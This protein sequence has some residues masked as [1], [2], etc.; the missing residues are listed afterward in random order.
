MADSANLPLQHGFA[1]SLPVAP[2]TPLP[3]LR[4]VKWTANVLVS[5]FLLG[6]GLWAAIAPLESAAVAGGALE[7][8][9]SRKTIQHLEGG[10]ISKILVSDGDEV[11]AGQVLMRLDDTKARTQFHALQ[12]QLW[13]AQAREARLIAERD[14]RGTIAV[15]R[16][17]DALRGVGA[18][19]NDVLAGQQK[20]L[21][22]RRQVFDSQIAVIKQR[23]AQVVQEITGLTAQERAAAKRSSIIRAE[24]DAV[25]PLVQKGLE[26]RPRLLALEREA[27]EIEG[28]RGEAAAQ[29]SRAY[30]VIAE[31]RANIIKLGSDRDNEI[32]QSLH[33]TQNLL[34]QL[35]ERI[36]AAVDQLS[37][38][39]VRAP[40]NGIVTDL[41]VRTPGGVVGAGT[42][43]MDLVPRQDRLIAHAQIRPED[44]DVV[45]SG[46]GADVQLLSYKQ[47]RMPTLKGT[48]VYVSADSLID[49][50]T[51]Q[52]YY[53][54]KIRLDERQLA[55]LS[56]VELVPGMPVQALIKTGESTVALYVLG[57]LLDSFNVAF[58]ED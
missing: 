54:A 56:D 17:A 37:R 55:Q 8:E 6:F 3:R 48:V 39:E 38:T 50:Q 20:I 57:P 41:R 49:K 28:R 18:L 15:P 40:E 9:S 21:D 12:S 58:R 5:V 14:G 45:H 31:S 33:E 24:L 23:M 30:Q 43:L 4:R 47:R 34:V 25:T 1:A 2:P 19:P 46:L 13:D 7:A 26:R 27:T 32:A 16:A 10:I 53:A 36:Q 51:Q 22:A 44:I 11:V 42:P 29:I 35:S 52:P